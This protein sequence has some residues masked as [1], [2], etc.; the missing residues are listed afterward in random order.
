MSYGQA[1]TVAAL[2]LGADLDE[3][4][5]YRPRG[6]PAGPVARAHHVAMYG[7][8]VVLGQPLEAIGGEA[9]VSKQAVSAVVQVIEDLRERDPRIAGVV[10]AVTAVLEA[11]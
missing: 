5:A 1:L 2:W 6:G 9:G 8:H 7:C 10:R 4:R 3:A 11:R